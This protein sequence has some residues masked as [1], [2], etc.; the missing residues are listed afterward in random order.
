MLRLSALIGLFKSLELHFNEP[1]SREWV[2][3]PN[4]GAEFNGAQPVDAMIDGGLLKIAR[5]R[6][7]LDALRGGV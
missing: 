5:V 7:Y 2:K 1:I 6:Q 4:G 3:L